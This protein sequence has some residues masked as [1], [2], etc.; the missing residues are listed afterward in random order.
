MLCALGF[1]QKVAGDA[2][3]VANGKTL[4][5]VA[6]LDAWLEAAGISDGPIFRASTGSKRWGT[7]RPLLDPKRT[8]G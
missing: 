3:P 6:A 4:T 1:D 8:Y 5:P 2:L 7:D